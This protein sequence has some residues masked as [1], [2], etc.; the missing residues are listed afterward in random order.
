MAKL[1]APLFSLGASQQLGKAL[2]FFGWKGLNVVREYVIPSNPK[3]TLQ[4]SQRAK[5]T[6]AVA[7]IHTAQADAD[8]PLDEADV[9]A[10]ALWAGVVQSAT[11][12]FNQA[13]RNYIDV[14]VDE[15]L[16][17]LCSDGTLDN[18][19]P[20]QLDAEIYLWEATC[21]A[22]KFSWGTSKTAL[23]NTEDAVILTQIATATISGLVPGTKYFVQFRADPADPSEGARSG[24]YT[25]YAT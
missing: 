15:K 5:L 24:I 2:V 22:G 23:I 10:Y 14:S 12:W 18:T 19:T 13:V 1:K 17:C 8:H 25:A 21:V 16:P 4:K 9:S 11:T 6:A 7:A 20:E 3:T